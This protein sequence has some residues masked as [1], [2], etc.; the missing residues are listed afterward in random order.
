MP[1]HSASVVERGLLAMHL[2]RGLARE[3][4]EARQTWEAVW[5]PAEDRYREMHAPEQCADVVVDGAAPFDT[6]GPA[7]SAPSVPVGLSRTL[8]V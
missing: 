7:A 3:G 5:M 4:A 2:P 1:R 8:R 6:A